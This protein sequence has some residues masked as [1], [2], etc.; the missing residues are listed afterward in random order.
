MDSRYQTYRQNDVNTSNRGKI[1]VMLYSGAITFLGKAKIYM[2]KNDFENRSKYIQKAINIIEELNIALDLQKGGEIAK[3]LRS[4]Y[5][6]VIR[7]LNAANIDNNT[8]KID[9][10]VSMIDRLKTAFEEILQ[11][12]ENSEVLEH[13]KKE[14]CQNTFKRLV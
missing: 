3:N 7:Y 14:Q 13:N 12:P 11:N 1:V 6:F 9:R 10:A 5:L 4:I 2:E 8:D